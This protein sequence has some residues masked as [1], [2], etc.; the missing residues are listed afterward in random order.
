MC[1]KCPRLIVYL[2]IPPPECNSFL[3]VTVPRRIH[4]VFFYHIARSDHTAL[5]QRAQIAPV[6]IGHGLLVTGHGHGSRVMGH[7]SRITGHGLR[8][9][10][11]ELR[12]ELCPVRDKSANNLT[13]Y[14]SACQSKAKL[15]RARACMHINGLCLFL[16]LRAPAR[17]TVYE[18]RVM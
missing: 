14:R 13:L 9:G 5:L 12:A 15:K 3:A 4:L 10:G 17:P 11:Y 2:F 6:T 1:G 8:A 18:L 16:T 7:G